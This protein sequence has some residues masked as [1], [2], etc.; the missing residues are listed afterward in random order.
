MLR[1]KVKASHITNLTDARYFA[2]WGVDWL[3][4]NFDEGS[5]H[6]IPP[7]N[8]KAIKE[9]VEGVQSV[10]EFSFS[11][12]TTINDA[13]KLLDLDAVQVGMF[14]DSLVLEKIHGAAVIKEVVVSEELPL[15]A[16]KKHLDR[17]AAYASYFLLSFEQ[18]R[19]SWEDLKRSKDNNAITLLQEMC[20]HF[21]I[22][23]SIDLSKDNLEEILAIPNL[24][25]LN[26]KGGA[27]EKVGV[28]SFEEL[29]DIFDTLL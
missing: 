26:L 22:M 25:G 29:D 15:A 27:E 11:N 8:M 16:V 6:Y 18:S 13:I 12:A 20:S 2:A 19:I 9:W 5:A 3:G 7:Q 17:Y 4:Y 21:R 28:K 23:L 10:G 14:T 1:T 24:Y